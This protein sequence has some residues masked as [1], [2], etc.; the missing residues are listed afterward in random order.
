MCDV[1]HQTRRKGPYSS[2]LI[3]CAGLTELPAFILR[4]FMVYFFNGS[5]CT[6]LALRFYP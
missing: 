6:G 3:N 1:V 2:E 5:C 4:V